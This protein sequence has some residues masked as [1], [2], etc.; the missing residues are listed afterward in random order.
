M[1]YAY[2][3]YQKNTKELQEYNS[4]FEQFNNK[5]IGVT[6]ITTIL[7][8]A[9]D[10]NE[11]NK[12]QKDENKQY[13]ENQ[14]NSIKIDIYIKDNDTTYTME[15]IYD[16]GLEK[17]INSFSLA[18]FKIEQITYHEKTKKIKYIKIIEIS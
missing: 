1:L 11:K 18:K 5:E 4:K 6:E 15:N 9:V 10:I 16:F 13:I 14:E 8:K 12:L 7:N 3:N 2:R 17:F